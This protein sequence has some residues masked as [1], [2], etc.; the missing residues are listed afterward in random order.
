MEKV[1]G[2]EYFR[3]AMYVNVIF[4]YLIF[5]KKKSTARRRHMWTVWANVSQYVWSNTQFTNNNQPA[6]SMVAL[7]TGQP[8]TQESRLRIK[9]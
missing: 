8:R 7:T 9:V 5:N 3:N 2:S 4:L 1:K 6:D